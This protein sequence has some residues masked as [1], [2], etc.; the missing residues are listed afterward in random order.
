MHTAPAVVAR[1]MIHQHMLHQ[2]LLQ[3]I[4]YAIVH[5]Q[6]LLL[7]GLQY[8]S[9]HCNK[10]QFSQ[11]CNAKVE[12]RGRG[13]RGVAIQKQAVDGIMIMCD[14]SNDTV[15]IQLAHQVPKHPVTNWNIPHSPCS[16]ILIGLSLTNMYNIIYN[17][18][19]T[20]TK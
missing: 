17:R 5:V 11:N 15:Y 9:A 1:V 14:G 10:T 7:Q 2:L 8:A 19:I 3:G 18:E 12:S 16:M 20:Q 13:K 4:Q 6:Q